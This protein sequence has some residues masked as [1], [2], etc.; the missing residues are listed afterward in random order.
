MT[1]PT[2]VQISQSATPRDCWQIPYDRETMLS[3]WRKK[4]WTPG[5]ITAAS[6]LT[7][8]FLI[9]FLISGPALVLY[10]ASFLPL[11]ELGN[12]GASLRSHAVLLGIAGCLSLIPAFLLVNWVRAPRELQIT[13]DGITKVWLGGLKGKMLPWT[14]VR[15]IDN[16]LAAGKTDFRCYEILLGNETSPAQMVLQLESL[17]APDRRESLLEA[18]E[19]FAPEAHITSETLALLR[20]AKELSFTQ[21][22]LEALTAPP[23]RERLIGLQAGTILNGRYTIQKRLGSG[24]QGAAYLADDLKTKQQVVLKESVLPVY[25]DVST[26]KKALE[27]FHKEAFALESVK[28]ASIVGFID[29]FVADHRAYLVLEFISGQTLSQLVKEKGPLEPAAV[30]ALAIKMC[31]MLDALHAAALVHRDFTPDNI[32]MKT[33][34][35]PVL[36]DFAAS[37]SADEESGDVSGKISYMAPEQFQGK[38]SATS[39]IYSF[40]CSLHFL[41]TGNHPESLCE[42]WP[43]LHA[44]VSDELNDVVAKAT[45]YDQ[46]Q[47]FQ[48][49]AELRQALIGAQQKVA[50]QV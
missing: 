3:R 38:P 6:W 42:C 43:K 19:R 27:A 30:I 34:G 40:G 29:S 31:D 14:A 10:L 20:P 39:D 12:S 37:A 41:L 50:P 26:R 16:R 21:V 36:I 47:R 48:T 7:V 32:I 44:N 11:D 1:E 15:S 22:W 2:Q 4:Y 13:R 8:L 28:C 23:K 9:G 25:A 17:E 46:A 33:S 24:G 49:V 35:E 18:I 45:K 5:Y